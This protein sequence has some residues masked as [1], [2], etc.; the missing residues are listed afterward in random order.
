MDNSYL[1]FRF[2]GDGVA[3]TS[4]TGTRDFFLRG[5]SGVPKTG[6]LEPNVFGVGVLKRLDPFRADCGVEG[7]RVGLRV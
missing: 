1:A 4:T 6:E 7:G 5:V 3:G 2:E